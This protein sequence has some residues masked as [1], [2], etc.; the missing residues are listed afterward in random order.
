MNREALKTLLGEKADDATIDKI[1]AMNGQDIEKFKADAATEKTRADGLK[2]SLDEANKKID[3]F[4]GMKTPEEVEAS[5]KEWKDKADQS[6]KDADKKIADMKFDQALTGALKELKVKDPADILPHLNRD[7]LKLGDDGKFIGLTEQ[8]T[9]LKEAKAYLF[10]EDE[11]EET[12]TL[13][14]GSHQ[15]AGG[16]PDPQLA[17]FLDAAGLNKEEKK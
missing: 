12:P 15:S 5:I 7:L 3:G 17:A 6:Q 8:I 2:T 9:P 1:M 10:A 11:N 13:V 14:T 4:K 16:K